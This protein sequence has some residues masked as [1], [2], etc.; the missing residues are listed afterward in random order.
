MLRSVS[1]NVYYGLHAFQRASFSLQTVCICPL[2]P[3]I[4]TSLLYPPYSAQADAPA[5]PEVQ[6]IIDGIMKL[7]VMQ[8]VELVKCLKTTFGYS[9]AAF[10]AAP[11]G[12]APAAAA[13]APAEEAAKPA[14]A[15]KTTV[16][17]KL[18]GYDAK[19]KVKIIKE[20]RVITGK[21]LK[22][23]KEL[24]EA[25]PTVVK[26][27]MKKEEAERT[28]ALRSFSSKFAPACT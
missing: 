10:M 18:E 12:G 20:V 15:V 1:R 28:L 27:D 21:G 8:S 13:A 16:S 24:V 7:N 6:A 19:D 9:D 14:A 3:H 17:L 5:S 11:S 2:V 4:L 23:A 22:E 25:A 26:A